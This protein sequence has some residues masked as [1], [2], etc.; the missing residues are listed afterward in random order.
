MGSRSQARYHL[1]SRALAPLL[2]Q[3]AHVASILH[4][5]HVLTP[6][7][8]CRSD[9]DKIFDAGELM[10]C[11]KQHLS[12][13]VPEG[14]LQ[15][16]PWSRSLTEHCNHY[17]RV[18]GWIL[19]GQLKGCLLPESG[20]NTLYV[21]PLPFTKLSRKHFAAVCNDPI[22]LV[23]ASRVLSLE[24]HEIKALVKQGKLALAKYSRSD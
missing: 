12:D 1:D 16:H 10:I 17:V 11:T 5:E 8:N 14:Y 22:S 2:G 9:K 18:L 7:N 20:F 21:E 24:E 13:H 4:E 19:N 6:L 15:I 23:M 3:E